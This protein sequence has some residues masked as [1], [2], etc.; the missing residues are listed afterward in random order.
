MV[1]RAAQSGEPRGGGGGTAGNAGAAGT[2]GTAGTGGSGPCS[3]L[4]DE[5]TGV[6]VSTTGS[7]QAA[8]TKDKPLATVGKALTAAV[9]GNKARVYVGPGVYDEALMMPAT[10][11]SLR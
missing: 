9:A 4:P 6:F 10:G 8:G 1:R 5:A 7:D 2:A 11:L 3:E